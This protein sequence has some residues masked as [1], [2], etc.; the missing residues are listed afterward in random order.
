MELLWG[1][2]PEGIDIAVRRTE[3]EEYY[4]IMNFSG[5]SVQMPLPKQLQNSSV[6]PDDK[7]AKEIYLEKYG[8]II[9]KN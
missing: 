8:Y 6:F 7:A 1:I 3:T 4:F 9:L 2:L 5:E